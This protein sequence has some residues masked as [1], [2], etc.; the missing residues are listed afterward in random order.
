MKQERID[1]EIEYKR[2][3]KNRL[4][5]VPYRAGH[6]EVKSKNYTIAS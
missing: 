2:E 6:V 3:I 4:G 5:P 1:R